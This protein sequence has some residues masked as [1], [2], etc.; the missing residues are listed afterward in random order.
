MLGA[1]LVCLPPHLLWKLSGRRS[2]WPRVFLGLAA[3]AVGVDLRISGIPLTKDVFF[4]CNHVSWMDILALGG[5]TGTAFIAHDGIEKW[6]VIGWLAAQ[7]NT[8]FVARERRR[9]VTE[10]VDVLRSALREHQPVTLFPEGTTGD[11][12]TLLPFKPA[13]FA[14]M[15]P[16]PRD[17]DVQPVYL[18]YGSTAAEIAWHGDEGAGANAARILGR[19]GKVRLTLHFLDPF[20]PEDMPDRK[21]IAAEARKRIEARLQP[22]LVPFPAV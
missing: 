18:D 19:K 15:M 2:P 7:N 3:R 5:A 1:L 22:S 13:L 9:G 14:V 10:Q 12:L 20:D 8:I 21:A 16:P 17:L 4:A 6:P 11:G